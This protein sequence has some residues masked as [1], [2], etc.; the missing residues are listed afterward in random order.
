VPPVTDQGVVAGNP[1]A[2]GVTVGLLLTAPSAAAR[3]VISVISPD[4]TVTTLQA[5]GSV[6][7]KGGHTLA[8]AVPR[9]PAGRDPF[10]I[11][12]TPQAGSGP[13]YAVRVVTSGTGGMSAP[14]TSL[15]PVPS[16]LA[17]I[18]LPPAENSDSAVMP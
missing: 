6:T 16:A 5:G 14:V 18:A 13:L 10:A 1:A 17:S 4:G 15:L 2:R 9:P 7:V 3:A 12:I 11:V 8:V